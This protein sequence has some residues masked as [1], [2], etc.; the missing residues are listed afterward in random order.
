MNKVKGPET[1]EEYIENAPVSI[2]D[3]LNKLNEI[4]KNA[5]PEA[6]EK[7]SYGMPAYALNG[8][9]VYFA[10]HTNHIGF[11]PYPSA[12]EAFKTELT[13]YH[14][15]K[16]SIQFPNDKPLPVELIRRIVEFRVNEKKQKKAV[17]QAKASSGK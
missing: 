15:S 7:I 1:I 13:G 9:L 10:A 16:G 11:Y 8:I 12:I 17:R 4:I 2:Q 3:R 6:R 5:A 14:S